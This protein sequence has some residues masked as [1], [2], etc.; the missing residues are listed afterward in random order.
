[1]TS[2]LTILP[3]GPLLQQP[4]ARSLRI[5]QAL[6]D[7]TGGWFYP[8]GWYL[9]PNLRWA[10]L[11]KRLTGVSDKH[12]QVI[13][14]AYRAGPGARVETV[15]RKSGYKKKPPLTP[16][17]VRKFG[18]QLELAGWLEIRAGKVHLQG[19][20]AFGADPPDFIDAV[21]DQCGPMMRKYSRQMEVIDG[22]SGADHF[23]DL[24]IEFMEKPPDGL[25]PEYG[26]PVY[27]YV[28]TALK[29]KLARARKRAKRL[30]KKLVKELPPKTTTSNPLEE[31]YIRQETER[32][33]RKWAMA[34]PMGQA[35]VVLLLLDGYNVE[36]I[37][38]KLGVTEKA[39]HSRIQR[40]RERG[41]PERFNVR[42]NT[43]YQ[44]GKSAQEKET[45]AQISGK[46]ASDLR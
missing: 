37:A 36:K 23:H 38:A 28:N 2:A 10:D 25:L 3:D 44:P 16:Y 21:L 29:R 6:H 33:I 42:S 30:R 17:E 15:A 19:T 39:V 18:D 27:G 14:G 12:R 46:G 26:Q 8:D 4:L 45:R 11:K 43:T 24:L 31:Q 13:W 9:E 5:E 7:I 34:L 32:E 35:E 41:V 20:P 40:V 1:M 22:R